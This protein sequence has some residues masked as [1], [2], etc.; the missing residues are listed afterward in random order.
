MIS[1]KGA[2]FP[3]EVILYAVFFYVRSGAYC[4]LEA[5]ME[6]IDIKV[7]YST[8][9]LFPCGKLKFGYPLYFT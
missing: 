7:D 2:H 4:D 6:E 3:K 8:L 1:F 9:N 5:I